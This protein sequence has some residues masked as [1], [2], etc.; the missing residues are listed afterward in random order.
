MS[1]LFNLWIIYWWVNYQQKFFL[2]W[3]TPLR[4]TSANLNKWLPGW[5]TSQL[6]SLH[7]MHL[8]NKNVSRMQ[9]KECLRSCW[10]TPTLYKWLSFSTVHAPFPHTVSWVITLLLENTRPNV[11]AF[12]WSDAQPVMRTGRNCGL[13]P[14]I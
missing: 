2:K 3:T 10:V 4:T 6:W 12:F 8:Y 13:S 11:Y 9:C 5:L 1:N 14:A 7:G